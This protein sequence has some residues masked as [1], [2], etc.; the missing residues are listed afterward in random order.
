MCDECLV[1]VE[2]HRIPVKHDM[3]AQQ[4]TMAVCMWKDPALP[5]GETVTTTTHTISMS[6][7]FAHKP[8]ST[9]AQTVSSSVLDKGLSLLKADPHEVTVLPYVFKIQPAY[10]SYITHLPYFL[11]ATIGQ[12]NVLIS[13]S[14][15]GLPRFEPMLELSYPPLI[16]D[17]NQA[18]RDT[19]MKELTKHSVTVVDARSKNFTFVMQSPTKALIK[20]LLKMDIQPQ[21]NTRHAI[22]T[23]NLDAMKSVLFLERLTDAFLRTHKYPAYRSSEDIQATPMVTDNTERAAK[24]Q[25]TGNDDNGPDTCVLNPEVEDGVLTKDEF[26]ALMKDNLR[27]L[28]TIRLYV[29]KYREE[30]PYTEKWGPVDTIPNADGLFF[31]YVRDLAIPDSRT[32]PEVV[33]KYFLKSLGQDL[34]SSYTSFKQLKS[35]WGLIKTTDF[36]FMLSHMYKVIH[37]ALQCQACVYP[38]FTGSV[39]EGCV[40]W[41][42]G[43]A[44]CMN[45][46]VYRPMAYDELQN[47][48]ADSSMHSK[49]ITKI[50]SMLSEDGKAEFSNCQTIRGLSHIVQKEVFDVGSRSE[51]VKVANHLCY[52]NKYWSTNKTNIEKAL[53]MIASYEDTNEINADVPMH[54]SAIFS[55][56][57]IESVLSAF[58]H[59]A[60]SFLIP[61]GRQLDLKSGSE[62]PKSFLVRTISLKQAV[63]DMN[64]IIEEGT[65]TNN[66]S[67]LSSK[68]QDKSLNGQDKR[69]VW[70]QLC[71]M[72]DKFNKKPS[73]KN[74]TCVSGKAKGLDFDL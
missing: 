53:Y 8:N 38:V 26:E 17:F 66:N 74:E 68:H 65:I 22:N 43:Y 33:S 72:Y 48:V 44:I 34:D 57:L 13:Q 29:A 59:Q 35:S 56:D 2:H 60:P 40:M 41:G 45:D 58:G 37:T 47:V 16:Y 62:P 15:P 14:F 46:R 49:S 69:E 21:H 71:S 51:L 3:S 5:R 36:G 27:P 73:A 23:V 32:V 30:N 20:E 1:P 50:K 31:P 52:S 24:R 12:K 63:H 28:S 11:K 6:L 61:N 18:V 67:Q 55:D 70:D 7:Y 42:S 19:T 4:R 64:Y 54:P 39:Y 25:R 10:A 9:T